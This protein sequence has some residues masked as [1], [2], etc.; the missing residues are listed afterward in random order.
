VISFEGKVAA[1][2][3]AGNGIGLAAA[4]LMA[5]HGARLALAD[6]DGARLQE[7]AAELDPGGQ[8]VLARA[9]DVADPAACDRLMAEAAAH[10]GGLDHLV[11]CAGIYPEK[12][13]KDTSDEAWRK[14]MAVNLDGTFYVCRAAQPHLRDGGSVVL[15]TSLAAQRGSYAHAAYAASKGAVQ[16][17]TRSLALELAPA[18]RVNA[19]A[20]GIIATSMTSDLIGQKGAQLLESTPL[21]RF[22]T[23]GEIAGAIAFLCSPLA[24]FVTG[25]VMQVNGGIY[26]A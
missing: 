12:L 16:S 8:R 24:G 14:L 21:R 13:V 25:E 10:F 1:I 26:I 2:T 9:L 22:G 15:M 6:L 19:V 20:P 23:A 11:H 7:V 4:R 18:I 5:A 17:F 3:G